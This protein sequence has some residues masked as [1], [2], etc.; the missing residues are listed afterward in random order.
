MKD[1]YHTFC[2][3]GCGVEHERP[4]YVVRHLVDNLLRVI[5]H[6]P[7]Q[8]HLSIV[9]TTELELLTIIH[10]Y[11]NKIKINFDQIQNKRLN[12]LQVN[13][14][15]WDIIKLFLTLKS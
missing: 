4:L 5:R 2:G 1:H 11:Q 15:N 6:T 3:L 7:R 8:L 9:A 12:K 13:Y 10:Q 14:F